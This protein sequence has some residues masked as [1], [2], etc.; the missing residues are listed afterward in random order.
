VI[1][2][3]SHIAR[4]FFFFFFFFFLLLFHQDTFSRCVSLLEN[5]CKSKSAA[6]EVGCVAITFKPN[7]SLSETQLLDLYPGLANN[8]DDDDDDDD[9]EGD[10][11]EKDGDGSDH[12]D[13]VMAEEDED[14]DGEDTFTVTFSTNETQIKVSRKMRKKAWT[15]AQTAEIL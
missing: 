9:E 2:F 4:P 14:L 15:G 6:S 13:E 5:A 10:E 1:L 7:S 12:D 8:D 3:F 11:E